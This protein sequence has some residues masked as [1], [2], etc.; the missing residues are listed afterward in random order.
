[1]RTLLFS[2]LLLTIGQLHLNSQSLS[3]GS[4]TA[5]QSFGIGIGLRASNYSGYAFPNSNIIL[6]FNLNEKFR[7]EPEFGFSVRNSSDENDY[8]SKSSQYKIE[9]NLLSVNKKD[10]VG[11]LF[12]QEKKSCWHGFSIVFTPRRLLW[13]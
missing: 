1:M 5:I 10:A 7:F 8:S 11:V 4:G 2:V 13:V 3:N 12:G 6:I 9:V